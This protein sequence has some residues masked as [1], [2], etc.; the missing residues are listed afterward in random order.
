MGFIKSFLVGA[1]VS[2]L[3]AQAAPTA[4]TVVK[5]GSGV[6]SS[7]EFEPIQ[8]LGGSGGAICESNWGGNYIP[9]TG[10]TVWGGDYVVGIQLSYADGSSSQVYGKTAGKTASSIAVNYGEDN[11]FTEL[12]LYGNAGGS[13]VRHI[14]VRNK[15][16]NVLNSGYA[17]PVEA[18]YSA[19]P[20]AIGSG[21]LYGFEGST[22]GTNI[23]SLGFLFLG[24]K[25][26][27]VD[28]ANFTFLN[29]PTGDEDLTVTDLDT[30]H[31]YN[32]QTEGVYHW[33]FDNQKSFTVTHTYTQTTTNTFA[34]AEGI[35]V[36]FS[37]GMLLPGLSFSSTT[38][39]TWTTAYAY[40]SAVTT[41]VVQQVQYNGD[42]DLNPGQGV[43]VIAVAA[44]GTGNFPYTS[45][46][47]IKL[48]NGNQYT[49]EENG[50]LYLNAVSD[51]TVDTYTD[52]NP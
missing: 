3:T 2:F 21:I 46:V 10:M 23:N 38:T 52:N 17:N 48:A 14:Q 42:G 15:A 9:V 29:P 27:E 51:A 26:V 22:D 18:G 40:M 6:C 19:F 12:V 45:E 49:F 43:D 32:N 37:G 47:T 36:G 50:S 24:S 11:P 5:R 1:A 30:A 8:A 7:P 31:F 33:A 28:V 41:T 4:S 20:Q 25:L 13:Y 44:V 35:M 34:T 16:G 39:F